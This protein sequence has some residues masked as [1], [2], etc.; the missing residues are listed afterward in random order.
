MQVKISNE[1]SDIIFLKVKDYKKRVAAIYL[2]QPE[3]DIGI[4]M[5][6]GIEIGV[7]IFPVLDVGSFDEARRISEVWVIES[8]NKMRVYPVEKVEQPMITCDH[9]VASYISNKNQV[10]LILE[11]YYKIM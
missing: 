4:V 1:L 9:R 5:K 7:D 3:I 2:K 11:N 6:S 8:N 10:D